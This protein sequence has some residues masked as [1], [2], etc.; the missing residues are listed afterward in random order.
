[1]LVHVG[2]EEPCALWAQLKTPL[3]GLSQTLP[4]GYT[5]QQPQLVDCDDVLAAWKYG[6]ASTRPLLRFMLQTL[7]C[8]GVAAKGELVGWCFIYPDG[9]IGILHVKPA[10]RQQRLASALVFR[11]CARERML[12]DVPRFG[13]IEPGTPASERIFQRLGFCKVDDMLYWH[14]QRRDDQHHAQQGW[15]PPQ[16]ETQSSFQRETEAGIHVDSGIKQ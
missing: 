14:F 4:A 15:S 10:H 16:T 6:T 12:T 13:F 9:A 11:L 1:M 5:W 3:P 2:P 7:P 8:V